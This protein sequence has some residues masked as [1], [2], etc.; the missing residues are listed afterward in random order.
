MN[1]ACLGWGSLIWNPEALLIQRRWFSDGPILPVEFVRQSNDGR[2]TLVLHADA[3]PVRT[4]WALMDVNDLEDARH[5]LRSREGI[6]EENIE[7]IAYLQVGSGEPSDTIR[8]TI[9]IWAASKH[10]DAVI[11]TN[12][13]ARFNNR[14]SVA[15][16]AQEALNYLQSLDATTRDIAENYIRRAP[17]QIDTNFRQ[18]FE[19][20]LGWTAI[21]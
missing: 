16:T 17:P 14:N 2:L 1:I 8:R 21:E 9:G 20:E 12:L 13:G 4:L 19:Q 11:W 18:L 15:P 6:S 10:L 3:K 5:S 7:R